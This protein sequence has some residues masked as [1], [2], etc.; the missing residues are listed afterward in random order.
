MGWRGVPRRQCQQQ[1]QPHCSP[2]LISHRGRVLVA[3]AG[4][5]GHLVLQDVSASCAA[6]AQHARQCCAE[7]A[8]QQAPTS[9]SNAAQHHAAVWCAVCRALRSARE[10]FDELH[11]DLLEDQ[12]CLV[13]PFVQSDLELV[14]V[15][16]RVMT[17]VCVLC[18]CVY[19]FQV[20]A[21]PIAAGLLLLDSKLGLQGW[22]WVFMLEG[23]SSGAQSAALTESEQE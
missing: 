14:L 17:G 3:T 4:W 9:K 10:S 15:P 16:A 11:T 1:M 8:A 20:V 23:G 12:L 21:A 19:V 22:Q 13:V 6:P 7:S 2:F 5:R 18:V